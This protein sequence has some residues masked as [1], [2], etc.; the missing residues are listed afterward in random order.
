MPPGTRTA[1]HHSMLNILANM[2]LG[3]RPSGLGGLFNRNRQGGVFGAVNNNRRASL[4][5][6][7]AS[8]AAPIVIKKLMAQ[9]AQRAQGAQ[10]Y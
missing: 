1:T 7:V 2:F 5:G 9:R 3:R 4:L 8:I 6:A 10:A